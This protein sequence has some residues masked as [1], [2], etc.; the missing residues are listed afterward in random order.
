MMGTV[1]GRRSPGHRST[2]LQLYHERHGAGR[3]VIAL[4]GYRETLYT[5]HHLVG[6]VGATNALYLFDLK[7]HGRSPKPR[8]DRYAPEDQAALVH[9]FIV[10]ENLADV[11]LMGHSMG[12]GISLL[13]AARLIAERPDRLASLVLI[14]SASY[15]QSAA[16]IPH[17]FGVGMLAEAAL[18][19]LPSDLVVRTALRGAYYDP[20]KMTEAEVEAYKVNLADHDG[21]HAMVTVARHVIPHD[22]EPAL[23][24]IDQSGVPALLICGRQ[25]HY[26]PLSSAQRLHARLRRSHLWTLDKCGHVPQGECPERV[27]PAIAAFLARGEMPV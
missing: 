11:T 15:P 2:I 19:V 27:V 25:D 5:W 14:G 6:P 23:A 10:R 8:D 17:M 16:A 18:H 7:G 21:I 22:I 9:D 24:A 20:A 3:P 1:S 26:V 12:G 13:L 4:H